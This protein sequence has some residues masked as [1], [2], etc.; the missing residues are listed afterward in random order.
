MK[1]TPDER[2]AHI[3]QLLNPKWEIVKQEYDRMKQDHRLTDGDIEGFFGYSPGKKPGANFRNTARYRKTVT[4]IVRV[5][6]V[7]H[8]NF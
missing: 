5:W 4:G 7:W 2:R 1:L 3:M 6:L 8:N